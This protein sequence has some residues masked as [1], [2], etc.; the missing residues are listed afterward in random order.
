MK[1]STMKKD[2]SRRDFLK[3]TGT[4]AL[5][6]AAAGCGLATEPTSAF[7]DASTDDTYTVTANVYVDKADAPIGRNAYVTNS[8][9]PPRNKPT[10]PVYNNAT[11]VIKDGKKLLT[12]PIV[13]DTFGIL[14]IAD[15]ST[16]G[17]VSV[18]G[19]T[20]TAWKAPFPWTTPYANRIATITFD[21]TN[22]AAGTSVATFSPS[23]EFAT[24]PLYR[25]DKA[26]NLHLVADLSAAQ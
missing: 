19:T 16:D 26:W 23:K 11:L 15:T 8:G 4:A 25:G 6:A 22:F 20:E 5:V 7:A 12:V 18:V 17:V 2:Y 3:V 21:V 1:G 10:S 13:N 14:S 9:N 24:F